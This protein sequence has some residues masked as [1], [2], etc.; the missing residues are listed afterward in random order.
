MNISLHWV[1]III[2]LEARKEAA[3]LDRNKAVA[4][5]AQIYSSGLLETP[6]T[7]SNPERRS[8]VYIDLPAGQVRWHFDTAHAHLFAHLPPYQG[9]WDGHNKKERAYR[10]QMLLGTNSTP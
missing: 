1:E 5:L 8:C 3:M 2:G 7:P 10:L 4:A 6:G 9:V